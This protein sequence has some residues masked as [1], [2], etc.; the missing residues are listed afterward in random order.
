[1]KILIMSAHLSRRN[2]SRS[3]RS[4][5][6]TLVEP[7]S[8]LTYVLTSSSSN[9]L[10]IV[11]LFSHDYL[12]IDF[13][14]MGSRKD[15]GSGNNNSNG[16]STQELDLTVLGLNSGTSMVCVFSLQHATEVSHY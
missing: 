3:S 4:S 13:E 11:C 14:M 8:Y 1:M 10:C 5:H 12:F 7:V 9:F 6:M 16:L 2:S 15:A